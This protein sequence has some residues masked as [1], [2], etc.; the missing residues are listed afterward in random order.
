MIF[1]NEYFTKVCSVNTL[2]FWSNPDHTARKIKNILKP[3]GKFVLA[4]EDA[5]Q[6]K[7]R[8]LSSDVFHLYSKDAVHDLLKVAGFS[9]VIRIE[10]KKSGESIFHCAV[11]E[12]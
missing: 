5:E 7:K 3:K 9:S 11:A 4:F 6:L 10:S 2:Y 12:K 8:N 1:E